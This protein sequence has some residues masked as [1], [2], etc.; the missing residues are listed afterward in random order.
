MNPTNLKSLLRWSLIVLVGALAASCGGD[1]PYYRVQV[2]APDTVSL[3][4]GEFTTVELTLT[5]I[6]ESSGDVRLSLANAPEGITLLPEVILPAAEESI[7]ASP[8][9]AVAANSTTQ[10]LVQTLLLAQDPTNSRTA[11]ATF[12]IV[13]LPKPAP[14][15]DF[16]ISV[17]PRQLSLYAGQSG[18]VPLT[19]TR[20]EGFTGAVTVSLESPTSRVSMQPV[21]FAP[22]ETTRYAIV[23]VD[24]SV[25]RL[26]L[27]TTLVAKSEDGRKATTGFTV[28]IR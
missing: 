26:P 9:L 11:G 5:R 3:T 27:A 25:T 1:V 10:G 7:T 21:T 19:L 16:S 12:F 8:T 17:D 4:P 6:A 2:D 22:G 28:N 23:A 14:Q 13:V 24:R 18:Q 20:A 15:P